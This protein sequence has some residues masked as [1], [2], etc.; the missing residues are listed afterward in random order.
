[1]SV[2]LLLIVVGFFFYF[3][4]ALVA[5]NRKNP[6]TTAIFVLNLLL[7]W[8]LIGWVVAL[9]WAF[10]G[11]SRKGSTKRRLIYTWPYCS[12]EIQPTAIKCRH[13]GSAIAPAPAR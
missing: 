1:M 9:V 7:G 4:P 10:S 2:L 12:E 6:N 5:S 8:S 11:E 3:L 13:C